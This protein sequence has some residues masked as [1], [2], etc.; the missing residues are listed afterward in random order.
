MIGG[1]R[2]KAGLDISEVLL[3][4]DCHISLVPDGVRG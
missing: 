4:K 2:V 1:K 3:E